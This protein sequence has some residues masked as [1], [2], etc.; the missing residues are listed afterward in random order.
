MY[1]TV[2][3]QTRVL[4][5]LSHTLLT[6]ILLTICKYRQLST[7]LVKQIKLSGMDCSA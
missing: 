5:T 7:F 2:Y 4:Y 3:T 6:E 1:A